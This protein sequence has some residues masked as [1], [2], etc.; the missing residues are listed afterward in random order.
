MELRPAMGFVVHMR[1]LPPT[2]Y[3][4]VLV[5]VVLPLS[6]LC[7]FERVLRSIAKRPYFAGIIQS[8]F[9]ACIADARP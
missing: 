5:N 6:R 3:P 9:L 7:D 8:T 4:R 2:S 1:F